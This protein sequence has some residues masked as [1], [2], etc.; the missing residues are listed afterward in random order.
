MGQVTVKQL[1]PTLLFV[2]VI[3]QSIMRLQRSGKRGE[4]HHAFQG[5]C[6]SIAVGKANGL[7]SFTELEHMTDWPSVRCFGAKSMTLTD[8][9]LSGLK[10]D[11]FCEC[12]V[13]AL[14]S[15]QRRQLARIQTT[16]R[17]VLTYISIA[18]QTDKA[19]TSE[20]GA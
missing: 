10:T 13:S 5:V 20:M 9:F 2:K 1:S 11:Y 18:S 15:R 7:G 3:G 4:G 16:K 17:R 8:R 12:F 14:L 6:G 19:E